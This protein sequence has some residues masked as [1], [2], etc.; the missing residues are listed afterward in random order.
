MDQIT[1]HPT[2]PDWYVDPLAKYLCDTIN[3]HE[4]T[5]DSMDLIKYWRWGEALWIGDIPYSV[6]SF[7]PSEEIDSDIHLYF[8]GEYYNF[9]LDQQP[10][11]TI[12]TGEFSEAEN[13][14]KMCWLTEEY[15]NNN[16]T[17]RNPLGSHYNPRIDKHVIHPGGCRNKIVKMFA[18]PTSAVYSWYFNTRGIKPKWL[19]LLKKVDI[20]DLLFTQEFRMAMVPDHGSMI[21]HVS[22][23]V[24]EIAGHL[25]DTY[26]KLKLLATEPRQFTSNVDMP[27]LERW[28]D[29]TQGVHIHINF[30]EGYRDLDV[31]AAYI[32]FALKRPYK[33]RYLEVMVHEA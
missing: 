12:Q 9:E 16:K 30:K 4:F 22:K 27:Y 23:E 15:L 11:K 29:N 19:K 18:D 5:H 32:L 8:A 10:I 13:F 14:T 21:P 1:K 25:V 33:G 17:F 7:D 2:P 28:K 6:L 31:Y 24:E 20:E 26:P 3:L